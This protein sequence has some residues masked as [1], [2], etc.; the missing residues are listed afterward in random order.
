[1]SKIEQ[2]AKQEVEQEN[3]REAVD[4]YKDKLKQPLWRKLFPWKV[5]FKIV[6]R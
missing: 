2:V 6:R 1:M 5:I 3:F 4:K